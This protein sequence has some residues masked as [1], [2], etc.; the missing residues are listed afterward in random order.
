MMAVLMS[1]DFQVVA[2][3]TMFLAIASAIVGSFSVYKGQSLI[4]DAIGHAAF[5]GIVVAFMLF[6]SRNVILLTLGAIVAGAV[7]YQTI[8]LFDTHSKIKLDAS[9]AI[10]LTGFF[11]LGM[12]LKSYI[13]GHPA[14][15]HISQSGLKGYIFGAAAYIT[16]SDVKNIIMVSIFVLLLFFIFYKELVISTFDKQY[17]K[18]VGIKVHLI[19]LVMLI[20]MITLISLGLKS[21]GAILIASFLIFPCICANQHSKKLKSVLLIAA[22][23]GAVSS[24]FGSYLSTAVKGFSTGPVI[25]LCMGTITLLSMVFG[26]Y[27]VLKKVKK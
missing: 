24:I 16:K 19:N 20:M 9:L 1:Y 22:F 5:P 6:Q 7:A 25:I 13:Q 14:Y 17:S 26:K 18:S 2:L 12:V 23:V 21:V 3:G 8:L 27:G 10:V 11:G 15:S 4:G